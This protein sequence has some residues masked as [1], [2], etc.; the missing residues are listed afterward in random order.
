MSTFPLL[1]TGAVMQYPA[2]SVQQYGI[3]LVVFL[4][5]T[6][7]RSRKLPGPLKRWV[8]DLSMLDEGEARGLEEFFL[9]QS[10]SYGSFTFTDPWSGTVYSDCSFA[11][12]TLSMTFEA[13]DRVRLQ[14][15]V[16][17]NRQ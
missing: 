7:Q 3:D 13:E 10:G 17:E 16:V 9:S 5:G 11:E 15:T 4:D 1:K 8:I 6:E 2:S 12:D 14:L